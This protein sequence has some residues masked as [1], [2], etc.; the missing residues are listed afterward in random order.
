M[1]KV[2]H[3]LEL[4][5]L[6]FKLDVV[7][8]ICNASIPGAEFRG[9]WVSGQPPGLHRKM[10]PCMHKVC[11]SPRQTKSQRVKVDRKSHP[12]Q[13]HYWQLLAARKSDHLKPV[14]LQYR[15]TQP[16]IYGQHILV[17]VAF[18]RGTQI[19]MCRKMGGHGKS[20]GRVWV[21][22]MNDVQ[23]FE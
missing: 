14:M 18:L 8:A 21:W 11:E 10:W 13:R 17:L 6:P 2:S 5:F 19:Q 4:H 1:D 22:S 3:S 23:N 9:L 15:V 16:R 12:W 7:T 20:L